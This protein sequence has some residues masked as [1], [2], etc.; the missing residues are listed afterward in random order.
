MSMELFREIVRQLTPLPTLKKIYLHKDGEPLLN[1][2]LEKMVALIKEKSVAH[3]VAFTTNGVLL[4]RTRAM[5]FAS[6]GL[7]E[8]NISLDAAT[9]EIYKLIKKCD[10]LEQIEKTI[11]SILEKDISFRINLTFIEMKENRHEVE[12]FQ[13][14]WEPYPVNII[15]N[16]YHDWCGYAANAERLPE[17]RSRPICDNPFYSLAINVGGSVT[18]CCM[19]HNREAVVG[20]VRE[21]SLADIWNGRRIEEVRKKLF[22]GD[23]GPLPCGNCTYKMKY[24]E[25][26]S[27]LML[28]NSKMR[29]RYETNRLLHINLKC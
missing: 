7:D 22:D 12:L 21:N 17:V 3:K 28:E 24:R 6:S 25:I 20:N 9:P 1:P 19:D 5:E 18:I 29:D 13:R 14:K 27:P 26:I 8:M 4:N 16:Q 23:N 11:M 10:K 2:E 15:I